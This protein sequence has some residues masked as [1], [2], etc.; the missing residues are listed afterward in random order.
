MVSATVSISVSIATITAVSVISAIIATTVE[1]AMVV[2]SVVTVSHTVTAAACTMVC[3]VSVVA[4]VAAGMVSPRVTTVVCVPECR[5]T[6]VVECTVWV[7]SEDA[8]VPVTVTP[9]ERTVEVK[10]IAECSVLPVD[11]YV[12]EVEVTVCPVWSIKVCLGSDT[13]EIVKVDLVCSF[14]LV[15]SKIKLISHLVSE[16]ES[17]FSSLLKTHC[18]C[19]E[20]GCEECYDSEKNLFHICKFFGFSCDVFFFFCCKV[21]QY[22]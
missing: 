22:L 11:E 12:A 4:I 10:G 17:L 19:T 6:E 8:E 5:T 20:S 13:H 21:K 2:C 9:I 18:V 7:A 1:A 3:A 15:V 16:E 14:I